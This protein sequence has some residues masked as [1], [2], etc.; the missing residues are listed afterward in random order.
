MS[1]QQICKFDFAVEGIDIVSILIDLVVRDR[2]D[3]VA[4]LQAR[5][6]RW[7]VRFDIGHVNAAGFARFS[8]KLA[9]FRITRRKK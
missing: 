8:G 6:H 5:F 9:Q 3:N 1:G 7:R 4:D 2:C